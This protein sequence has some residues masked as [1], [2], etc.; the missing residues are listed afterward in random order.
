LSVP[1]V[2]VPGV[3]VCIVSGVQA[4][5]S[6]ADADSEAAVDWLALADVLGVVLVPGAQAIS[7]SA[8]EDTSA[9][10]VARGE[11]RIVEEL[12][13]IMLSRR[14]ECSAADTGCQKEA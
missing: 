4:A 7:S 8:M 6:L 14:R 10:L 1:T 2:K 9:R 11:R 13:E 3:L 5:A 12:L